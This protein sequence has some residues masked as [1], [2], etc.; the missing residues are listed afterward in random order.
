MN[1][2]RS[3]APPRG[4]ALRYDSPATDAISCSVPVNRLTGDHE[5]R[6]VSVMREIQTKIETLLPPAAGAPDWR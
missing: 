5:G 4:L 3:S 1:P 6:I 2:A